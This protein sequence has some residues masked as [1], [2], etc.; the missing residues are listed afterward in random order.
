MHERMAHTEMMKLGTGE[1]VGSL[2]EAHEFAE[3]NGVTAMRIT[4]T[5]D[6]KD[7]RDGALASGMDQEMEACYAQLDALCAR[8]A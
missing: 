1:Q 3:K 8:P 2:L 7:A 4:Q 5:Y 6:S